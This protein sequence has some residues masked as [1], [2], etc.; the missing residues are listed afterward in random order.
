MG[1]FACAAGTF[2]AL[3]EADMA[4]DYYKYFTTRLELT[5]E[6]FDALGWTTAGVE[7]FAG[8]VDVEELEGCLDNGDGFGCSDGGVV[9]KVEGTTVWLETHYGFPHLVVYELAARGW[10]VDHLGWIS[11][12]T[13]EV[14]R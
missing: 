12:V 14:E 5:E 11:G 4:G 13:G 3:D 2:D 1:V 7:T 10:L 9:R 8:L 6:G